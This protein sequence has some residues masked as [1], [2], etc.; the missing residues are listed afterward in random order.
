MQKTGGF[1]LSMIDESG[2][3]VNYH[4]VGLLQRSKQT[5]FVGDPIQLEP[6][7]TIQPSIDLAIASD[8]LPISTQDGSRRWGDDYMV[9][10]SSAQSLG[11]NAGQ[12]S[13]KIGSRKVGIPLLV[14]RRCNEPMFSVSNKIAYDK[15]MVQA[16]IPYKWNAIQ[17]GWINVTELPSEVKKQGYANQKEVTVAFDLIKFL[18][19]EQP[20]MVAGGV[21]II[22]PFSKMR[23]ELKT[24]WTSKAKSTLNH[25][26]MKEA[27]GKDKVESDLSEF[28]E[29][30][31]GTVHTFQGKEASTVI[32]CTAASKVRNK[33]GGITWVNSKPNLLNVAVTRAKHHLFVIG[34]IE[35]W[36]SGVLSSEL[37][38][39]G[40][41]C[42]KSIECF[43]LQKSFLINEITKNEKV[44]N[45]ELEFV[46]S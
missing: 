24:Q 36:S 39:S 37:Q 10:A 16:S 22:T 19:E 31:I 20:N 17:S 38:H 27:F 3:A 5:I 44:L 12:F 35:D 42:Y 40:M 14:H 34:N 15:R 2:Q 46:F 32:M 23:T 21:Y 26:W 18:V 30:N 1:G 41:A 33:E 11:D 29:N 28:A 7:V 9:S 45:D 8:F 4:V 6:V 13:A 25:E 43:K